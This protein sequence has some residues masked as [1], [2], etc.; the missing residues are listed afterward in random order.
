MNKDTL[1]AF[2]VDPIEKALFKEA[3]TEEGLPLSLWIR[4]I[5]ISSIK[6]KKIVIQPVTKDVIS[7]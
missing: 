3:A 4:R 1:L 2:R 6:R 7:A 5:L